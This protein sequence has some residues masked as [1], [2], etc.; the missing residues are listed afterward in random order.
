MKL[1]GVGQ[2]AS[3]LL[4][5]FIAMRLASALGLKVPRVVAITLSN[6]L[7]WQVGSDEFYEALQR[8]SGWNL[9]V[10]FVDSARD[11]TADDLEDIPVA[12]LDRL[13]AVDALLQNMDRTVQNPNLLRDG[14]PD[15][16]AIDFGACLF[17]HRFARYRQ[18]MSFELPG[19]HFLAG[20][21]VQPLRLEKAH[22]PLQE[23]V[24]DVPDTWLG[25]VDRETLLNALYDIIEVYV[26]RLG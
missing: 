14:A 25:P 3:G 22:V 26:Q 16:W 20:R 13:A 5:E 4:T 18:R 1:S 7:P 15:Y 2:G 23:I 19:N 9:G 10:E 17:L 11:L 6:A 12:F 21:S 24:S 8:S